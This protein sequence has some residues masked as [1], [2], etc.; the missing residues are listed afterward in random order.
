MPISARNQIKG[1]VVSITPGEAI[2][3]IVVDAGGERIVAS[4]TTEAASELELAE[5]KEVTAIIKGLRRD[6]GHLR[7]L[8]GLGSGSAPD[9]PGAELADHR[10]MAPRYWTVTVEGQ[11][12]TVVAGTRGQPRRSLLAGWLKPAAARPARGAEPPLT[13]KNRTL[14]RRLRPPVVVPHADPQGQFRD[15]VQGWPPMS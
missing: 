10:H 1:T 7:V 2:E 11:T 13:S 3:N 6:P 9:V 12:L 8:P 5:G 4:I 15:S 14:R